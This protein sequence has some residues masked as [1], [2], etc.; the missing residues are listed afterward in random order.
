MCPEELMD[1]S[2]GSDDFQRPIRY[3]A[4]QPI[5]TSRE[6]VVGYELLFRSSAENHFPG[7][8][9]NDATR[10]VIDTSSLHGLDILCGSSL[11][12]INCTKET[13]LDGC[14]TLLPSDK[15]V[16]EI[17]ETVVPDAEV[18]QAC[19]KLKS[20]GYRIALDDFTFDDH[21][22]SLAHLADYIKVDI[23]QTS[24]RDAAEIIARFAHP[25]CKM[26][27]EKVE[28][29][30]EFGLAKAARFHL[31]QGYFFRE[32]EVLRTRSMLSDRTT[33]FRLLQAVS[34]PELDWREVEDLIRSDP[35]LSFRLLRYLDTV[36]FAIRNSIRSLRQALTFL[37]EDEIR[38]WCRLSVLL[39]MTKN[40]TSEL[41]LCA[42][43]RAR[44]C[45]LIGT[46]VEHGEVDL[47][48]LGLLSLID[49]ILEI[50]MSV[51]VEILPI[52]EEI[53]SVLLRKTGFLSILFQLVL[54]VET[55]EQRAASLLCGRLHLE[56]RFV[57][58]SHWNAMRWAR[59]F[60]S[61]IYA[62]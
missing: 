25:R 12:F 11:A 54:E 17:L 56:E 41:I 18:Q 16:I 15:V 36:K 59:E 14:I 21:R 26:L 33:C 24:M 38:R 42:A 8:D 49:S 37:G 22:E 34:K 3:A 51:V 20:M 39:E 29:R 13:L 55:G 43:T 30:E 35:A 58:D 28:T 23:R 40:R 5:L 7:V 46:R 50:P 4:R 61:V 27:A 19:A 1:A 48:L 57:V 47:F 9:L 6:K 32:P 52:H 44:F 45:E 53:K 10:S 31:F 60:C 2:C 62:C